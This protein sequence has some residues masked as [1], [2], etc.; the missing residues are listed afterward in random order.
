VSSLSREEGAVC[1]R[2]EQTEERLSYQEAAEPGIKASKTTNRWV[3]LLLQRLRE[4]N[5]M[6]GIATGTIGFDT[7]GEISHGIFTLGVKN[8]N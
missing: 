7:N 8:G 6:A 5:V 4:S 3:Q 1:I 2:H